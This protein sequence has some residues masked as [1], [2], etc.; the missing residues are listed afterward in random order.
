MYAYRVGTEFYYNVY[1]A[2]RQAWKTGNQVEFYCQ[3]DQWSTYNWAQE[4]EASL[5]FLMAEY[6]HRLRNQNERLI[7]AYSGG[8]DSQTIYNVFAQNRIHLDEIFVKTD[9]HT[10][11]HPR[12]LADW[13]RKNHW[14]PTTII[15]EVFNYDHDI[16]LKEHPDEDW[17]WQ[18]QSN[19]F[20]YAIGTTQPGMIEQI[21]DRHGGKNYKIILGTEKP[22][23]VY[24][25]GNWHHRQMSLCFNMIMGQEQCM[26]FFMEPLIAIKQSHL[27][28]A[29]VK[30]LIADNNLS[31]YND[32]W[33]EA[34]WPKTAEGYRAWCLSTGRH[35]ELYLGL[36]YKQ[37]VINDSLDQTEVLLQGNWREN[38]KSKDIFLYTDLI[39]DRPAAL[40]Y[41]RGFANLTSEFGFHQYLKDNGWFRNSEHSLRRLRFIWCKEQ[42]I[43]S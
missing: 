29:G 42:N 33:A 16:K 32:D 30:K 24:R 3:D 19:L 4:P 41:V 31:L 1:L 36:S 7:L 38:Y 34:K 28:K 35:D 14:D 2:L 22:R 10:P 17:I 13:L 21:S 6:A 5:D 9:D 12:A 20:L 18:N 11:H 27:V 8:T 15:T 37:K 23:I 25:D 39:N 43:G 40:N 26:A